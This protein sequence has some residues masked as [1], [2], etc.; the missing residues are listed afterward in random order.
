MDSHGAAGDR[1]APLIV[2]GKENR[3][4]LFS[5]A[6]YDWANSPF[7]SIIE[8]FIFAAYFTRSVAAGEAIGS[9]QW[10]TMVGSAGLL[11]AAGGPV[12]GAIADQS[13]RRKPWIGFFT[14]LCAAATMLL[15]FVEPSPAFAMLGLVLAGIGIVGA[16]YSVIFYNA[17]LSSLAPAERMG[18]WSGWG[19]G[20]GYAGGLASL[21][22]ALFAF[23]R[24]ENPW[25]NLNR[26][27]AEHVRITFPLAGVWLLLFAIPLFLFTPDQRTGRA[28]RAV[29]DGLRQL[30][31]SF[32][33]V[34][35]YS[36]ILRFLIA[37]MI[38]IDG[39]TTIFVFGGVYAAGTFN[40]TEQDVLLFGIALNVTA[41]IGAAVFGWVDD[42]IGSKRTIL[43]SLVGLV[44]PVVFMLKTNSAS[45]FWTWG[46]M[47]G[48]FVGP[49]QAASRS[50]LARVAPE[51]LQTQMFGLF[52]F[53]GKATS[54][55]G[56]LLVGW[57]TY[58]AGSQRTG[59]TV[60]VVM[61]A[62]GFLLML[63]VP[64]D[65]KRLGVPH[66]R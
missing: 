53:S 37:R 48:I 24:P 30:R 64:N 19:W 57:I 16:E 27:A 42:W 2:R 8:T 23:I 47:L 49:A 66:K 45:L 60:I 9:A 61:L 38:Y 34:R 41:G 52:A 18:R 17:M 29:G 58:W 51:H 65:K 11:I 7:A 31:D 62:L 43:L 39:L 25:L 14:L 15:W 59:M 6:L 12:L 13:G 21:I 55:I 32:A 50:Y 44:I 28:A 1:I 10:G 35:R 33:H 54:F 63:T 36:G 3:A 40:M 26:E 22:V 56:P 20:L 4:G 5:W 46:L